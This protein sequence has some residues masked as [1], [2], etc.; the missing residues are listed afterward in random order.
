MGELVEFTTAKHIVPAAATNLTGISRINGIERE[1]CA[2][3]AI[4]PK[5]Q[6]RRELKQH[7]LDVARRLEP[8]G[9]GIVKAS[10]TDFQRP[11]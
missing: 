4:T 5:R 1:R 6:L 11:G 7:L 3:W 9:T 10:F 2:G 8:V